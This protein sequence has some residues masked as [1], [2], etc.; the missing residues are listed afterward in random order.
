VTWPDKPSRLRPLRRWLKS[1]WGN[2]LIMG[3]LIL[4][5]AILIAWGN[6]L[7]R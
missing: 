3:A 2:G 1:A 5:V 4:L 7:G 6:S